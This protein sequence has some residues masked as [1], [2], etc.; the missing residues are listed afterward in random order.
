MCGI[1]GSVWTDPAR[2]LDHATLLRM[3]SQLVHRGPD[4]DGVFKA[5]GVAFGHR[6]LSIIGVADGRQPIA[7]EDGSVVIV[8]N[9]EIYNYLELKEGLLKNGHTFQTTTDTEVVVHL[10]EELGTDTFSRLNGMFALAIWDV[11]K[12]QLVLARDRLG[13]KPLHYL[14]QRERIVFASELKAI[15]QLPDLER[16]VNSQAVHSYLTYLYIPHPM[17]VY[18]GIHKLEP[19]SFAVWKQGVMRT[20][21]YWQ[22][23]FSEEDGH[24]SE[25]FWSEGLSSLL[26][27]A[28]KLRMQSEVPFGA[29]LSGGIDSSIVVG[30]MKG[31]STESIHTFSIGSPIKEFDETNYAR[32]VARHLEVDHHE[33]IVEPNALEI[34]PR[35][36]WHYDEP[37]GDSSAIPTWCV[38]QMTRQHVTV[39]LTGDGGDELFAGYERYRALRA[40]GV[41]DHM[42][43]FAR[44][45]LSSSIWQRIPASPYQ[46]SFRRRLK[47]YLA[48]AH[49]APK[50]LFLR[51]VSTF[52]ESDKLALYT[53]DFA[54]TVSNDDPLAFVANFMTTYQSRDIVTASMLADLN[55]YL[56]CDLM[57]KVDIASMAHGLECRAPFLDYRVVEFVARM[58]LRYKL[59]GWRTKKILV[60]TF[61]HFLPLSVRKR[62][63]MGFGVPIIQWLR[64][65]LRELAYDTLTSQRAIQRGIFNKSTV[66][67]MLDDHIQGR[68]D[69][70]GKLWALLILEL[71]YREWIDN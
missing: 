28:V 49:L 31:L 65:P 64:G 40:A 63:K 50:D 55:T 33:F 54:K 34:L 2:A 4:E 1:V 35:L 30:L 3:M 57:T 19:G 37:M 56:I 20:G 12:Q 22:P 47:R 14:S 23:D 11:N 32:E 25:A 10:Y 8:M 24:A 13:K 9:G 36:V 6:R 58:P 53:D 42:P 48:I 52:S 46:R 59:S 61:C 41:L 67:A 43:T 70:A 17:T 62:R 51:M 27:D 26:K 29:F 18:E 16:R 15:V 38:S 7:S 45:V 69:Y 71:W 44:K 60:D 21:R 39:A 66:S 68:Q 5:D